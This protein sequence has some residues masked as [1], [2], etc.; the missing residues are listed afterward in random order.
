M[1]RPCLLMLFWRTFIF[2]REYRKD[3]SIGMSIVFIFTCRWKE[4]YDG[5]DCV[6]DWPFHLFPDR[7]WWWWL[8][9][10]DPNAKATTQIQMCQSDRMIP[11]RISSEKVK[12]Q[13]RWMKKD[14]TEWSF[15]T[16]YRINRNIFIVFNIWL[17]IELNYDLFSFLSHVLNKCSFFSRS[18]SSRRRSYAVQHRQT[19]PTINWNT[20]KGEKDLPLW[21]TLSFY[22]LQII[23]IS[24]KK[25]HI[26]TSIV[27]RTW[28]ERDVKRRRTI[29]M[30]PNRLLDVR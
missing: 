24:I 21:S 19:S 11:E 27:R 5:N 13:N 2:I 25:E 9:A 15:S 28:R 26:R 12:D 22:H 17:S 30:S 23:I 16:T 18:L 4:R 8:S 3:K 1:I 6:F 20:R 29:P 10:N 7:W 14:S